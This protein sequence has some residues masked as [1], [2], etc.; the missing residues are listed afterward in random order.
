MLLVVIET[1]GR[2]YIIMSNV[3]HTKYFLLYNNHLQ[4]E[5][6]ISPIAVSCLEIGL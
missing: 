3:Q 5:Q 6:E 1:I 4:C 2:Q